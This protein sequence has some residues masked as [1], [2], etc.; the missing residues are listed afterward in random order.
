MAHLR[1]IRTERPK[2]G[3][4]YK[5]IMNI[6]SSGTN[7]SDSTIQ[8]KTK[9]SSSIVNP[10]ESKEILRELSEFAQ[11]HKIK[12]QFSLIREYKNELKQP[13]FEVRLVLGSETY[14]GEGRSIKSAQRNAAAFAF[15]NTALEK[16]AIRGDVKSEN[17][18]D[19]KHNERRYSSSQLNEHRSFY[20]HSNSKYFEMRLS[21][22]AP[23][24]QQLHDMQTLIREIERALK[25]VSDN[26]TAKCKEAGITVSD[27]N[28]DNSF[29]NV[30]QRPDD[31]YRMLKGVMRVGN[32]AKNIILN[33]DYDVNLVLL[34]AQKPTVS[35]LHEIC[36]DMQPIL[37]DF[38]LLADENEACFRVEYKIYQA[39]VYLSS[40]QFRKEN[41][42]DKETAQSNAVEDT[43]NATPAALSSI[44]KVV[45]PDDLLS[46]DVC[47][48]SLAEVRHAKWFQVKFAHR[49]NALKVLRLIRDLAIRHPQPW[50]EI[51]QYAFELLIEHC[52]TS[53]NINPPV[54]WIFRKLLEMLSSGIL[55]SSS[56]GIFDPCEK[57]TSNVLES[58]SFEARDLMTAEAQYYLRLLVFRRVYDVLGIPKLSEDIN[59]SNSGGSVFPSEK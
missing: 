40:I 19:Q 18:S 47:L 37:T 13:I 31:E 49:P 35:L 11:H 10:A 4:Y 28:T 42:E 58:I 16:P 43:A 9:D 46:A 7:P 39:K 52:A 33:S 45:E 57:N 56:L 53:M 34:C 15:A 36:T 21:E 29:T 12:R 27:P 24:D 22:I 38:C 51:P 41:F 30:K 59:T 54:A 32:M 25:I 26:M 3:I 50:S 14:V 2:K 1:N 6:L 48:Q 5:L 55:Y 17:R 23:T 20:D 44:A 8:E